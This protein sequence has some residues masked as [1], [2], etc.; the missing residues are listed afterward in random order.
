MVKDSDSKDLP[1]STPSCTY[2]M[3]IHTFLDDVLCSQKILIPDLNTVNTD[4]LQKN[5]LTLDLVR[6][7][8]D[9]FLTKDQI[10]NTLEG[11]NIRDLGAFK[12]KAAKRLL[13]GR[14]FVSFKQLYQVSKRILDTWAINKVHITK[15][16]CCC[17]SKTSNK[18]PRL[19]EDPAKCMK[20]EN[21]ANTVYK[22]PFKIWYSFKNYC[23]QKQLKNPNIFYWVKISGVN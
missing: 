15:R 23:K 7:I 16:L 12:V 13:T 3:C 17:Y 20:V 5:S 10:S 4:L 6:E 2:T 9:C 8:E 22:C 18:R 21:S 14:I 11:D 19:H 1:D